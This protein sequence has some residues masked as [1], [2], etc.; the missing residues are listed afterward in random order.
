MYYYNY[1]AIFLLKKDL[2]VL[3]KILPLTIT[4]YF[5]NLKL[6]FLRHKNIIMY[7]VNVK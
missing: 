3:L 5:F 2:L 4:I 7:S 1:L 6:I